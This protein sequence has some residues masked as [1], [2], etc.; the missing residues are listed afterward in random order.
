MAAPPEPAPT[1]PSPAIVLSPPNST[2]VV[3]D[4]PPD[5]SP[6]VSAS[7]ATSAPAPAS[8]STVRTAAALELAAAAAAATAAVP[9]SQAASLLPSGAPTEA[10]VGVVV[11]PD[12]LGLTALLMWWMRVRVVWRAELR[13]DAPLLPQHLSAHGGDSSAYWAYHAESGQLVALS[14]VPSLRVP[15]QCLTAAPR[16]EV[17]LEPCGELSSQQQ[18]WLHQTG[19][20]GSGPSLYTYFPSGWKRCLISRAGQVQGQ[21]QG[22]GPSAARHWRTSACASLPASET[23]RLAT[24]GGLLQVGEWGSQHLSAYV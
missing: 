4:P 8:A 22:Q 3:A 14:G 24:S 11:A 7:T 10:G 23:L 5:P 17:H 19:E 20:A 6:V 1:P 13:A 18:W 9:A 15:P 2:S 16:G 21:G 12:I